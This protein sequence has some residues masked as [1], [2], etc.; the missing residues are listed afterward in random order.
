MQMIE[1]AAERVRE[2]VDAVYRSE[3]R[4]ILATLIRLLG[5]FELAED[6]LHDAFGAAL[7][8]WSK[9][10]VPANPRAWL[11]S[12]GRF[13]AIDAL[14]RRARFDS[15]QA[16]IA[17]QLYA[18]TDDAAAL[19]D[20]GIEDDRLRLIFTCCHPALG[21]EARVALTLREVCG[22]TTE[23]IAHAF[24]I[25]PSALAQRIVRAKAKIRD[26]RIPYQVPSP[27]ELPDRLVT[28]H[29]VIYLVFN[30]GYFASSGESLTR[31]DLSGEAIRLGRLLV[32]L[33]PEPEVM[34]LLALMLLQES[35]RT[36]RTSLTGD[37]ILLEDQDRSL[38]NRDQIAE[39]KALVERVLS[40]R[41]F[42]PYTL[43]AAIAAVH[44]DAPNAAATDWAQIAG[45]YELLGRVE[46][47]PVVELNRAVAVAMRDGPAAGLALIDAIL[48]RGDLTDY[49]LA[50]AARADL[51]RRLGR[52]TEARVSYGRALTLARQEPERR[53]LERRLAESG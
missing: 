5:D 34:G 17:E 2:R 35:R 44:A 52:R 22:L 49:H 46:P 20:E 4:R 7:D 18:D 30:E 16:A 32:E 28:V 24:L 21:P 37:L 40:S 26:A 42:G 1:N 48:A 25:V 6:A 43:Q 29:Q 8:Q 23:E 19:A 9:E 13:K 50:H 14:R 31:F 3:S 12:T 27:A 45:L 39:G 10:G 53:F 51:C 36:A 41:R 15:S 38:W 33:L 47:S 11:V